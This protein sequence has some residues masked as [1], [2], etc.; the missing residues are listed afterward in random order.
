M[1]LNKTP[2]ATVDQSSPSKVPILTPGNILP[3]VMRQF[4]HSCRNY[5][6]H[7]KIIAD[8]QVSLI[9]GGILDNHI[10]GWIMADHD[11]LIAL[12]FDAFMIEFCANYLAEDWEEDT[13]H[14]LLSMTQGTSTFWDYA[15]NLQS[16]NSLLCGTTSH[17]SDDILRQQLGA[18]MEVRLSKKAFTEKLNKVVDFRKWLNEVKHCDEGL[19]AE[20]EE[21]ERI[22]KENR[23]VSRRYPNEPSS[24]TTASQYS[25]T[26]CCRCHK[27][28][29]YIVLQDITST[30]ILGQ[31]F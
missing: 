19:R 9:I 23:D 15:I 18:G 16:K 10:N 29:V 21:Y 17:L 28:E 31:Y 12:S 2:M 8:D 22:A 1:P 5:F 20:R 27:G 13:L 6:I 4:E 24:C 14:K 26:F 30:L 11:C 3:A 25:N 7:K